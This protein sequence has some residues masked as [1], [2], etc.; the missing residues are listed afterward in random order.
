MGILLF[1]VTTRIKLKANTTNN[2]LVYPNPVV[3]NSIFKI[4]YKSNNDYENLFVC[5]FDQQGRIVKN[6]GVVPI[7]GKGDQIISL[8]IENPPP[9]Y[10]YLRVQKSTNKIE[11]FS[12]PVIVIK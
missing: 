5:L 1:L 4:K 9:G 2:K 7:T 11:S 10:Y 8:H 12:L 6:Y 3:Q